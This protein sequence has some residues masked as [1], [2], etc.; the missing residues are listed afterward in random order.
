MTK[1]E[2]L[3]ACLGKPGAYLDFSFG[4]HCAC[5]KVGGR[6]IA[7]VFTLQDQPVA[8]LNCDRMTGE[9]FRGKYPG[10]VVR[11]Y[12][13]PP[14]QQPYF[15]TVYLDQV[16]G[17]DVRALIDHAYAVVVAKLPKAIRNTLE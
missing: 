4:P 1:D 14:V 3:S 6:L 16:P 2:V 17:E 15:N 7:Q 12:H 10:A 9:I 11:G 13:C 5:V 8:T